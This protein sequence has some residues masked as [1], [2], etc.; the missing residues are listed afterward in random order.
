MADA[1]MDMLGKFGL[2]GVI[3]FCGVVSGAIFLY[4]RFLD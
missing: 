3:I 4:K 2:D 1:V